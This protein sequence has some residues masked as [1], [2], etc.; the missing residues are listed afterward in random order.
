MTSCRGSSLACDAAF[1]FTFLIVSL[2]C[3]YACNNAKHA[4]DTDW[5]AD[6][7][8]MTKD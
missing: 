2:A 8:K 6:R 5:T 4:P 1:W 3:L 7:K